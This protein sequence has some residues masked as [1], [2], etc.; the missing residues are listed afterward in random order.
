MKIKFQVKTMKDAERF[1][2]ICKKFPVEFWIRSKQFCTD[3]KSTL[4]VLALMYS[5][6]DNMYIDT[7]DMDD[8][9]IGEFSEKA[10]E[11]LVEG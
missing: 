2:N 1:S 6:N 5:D 10:D 11:F 3:P 9:T 7:G 8:K 4:G